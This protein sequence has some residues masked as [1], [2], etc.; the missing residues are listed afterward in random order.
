[1][2]E[3]DAS[4]TGEMMS[5]ASVRNG[6]SEPNYVKVWRS[7]ALAEKARA[8]KERLRSCDLCARY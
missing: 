1:M 2:A 7:G 6:L 4:T 5:R 3:L 8:A